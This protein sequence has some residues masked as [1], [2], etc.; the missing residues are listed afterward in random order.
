[1]FLWQALITH[2]IWPNLSWW[3]ERENKDQLLGEFEVALEVFFFYHFLVALSAHL[4]KHLSIFSSF[5]LII[6]STYSWAMGATLCS[7][8][9]AV[10]AYPHWIQLC[11]C[12]KYLFHSAYKFSELCSHEW[13]NFL[14]LFSLFTPSHTLPHSLIL[15]V[16]SFVVDLYAENHCCGHKAQ[17]ITPDHFQMPCCVSYKEGSLND[18]L[19][20]N[21]VLSQYVS[22]SFPSIGQ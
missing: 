19:T 10:S 18:T 20:I 12:I 1:M 4:S 14:K 11:A 22:F 9:V 2:Q 21:N 16:V 5:F 15:C 6:S 17:Y 7:L 8:H 13:P 3:I